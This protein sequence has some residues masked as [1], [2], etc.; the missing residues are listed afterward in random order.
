MFYKKS[1]RIC[2][3]LFFYPLKSV[4]FFSQ[5]KSRCENFLISKAVEWCIIEV[6]EHCSFFIIVPK[7]KEN[8]SGKITSEER[9]LLHCFKL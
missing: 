1:S 5:E 6:R 3:F 4:E 2:K 7:E 9:L 8:G